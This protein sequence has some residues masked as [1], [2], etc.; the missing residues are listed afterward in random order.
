MRSSSPLLPKSRSLGAKDSG[1]PRMPNRAC[2]AAWSQGRSWSCWR[3]PERPP[4]RRSRAWEGLGPLGPFGFRAWAAKMRWSARHD[5]YFLS[6]C[7]R[8]GGFRGFDDSGFGIQL[9]GFRVPLG[10]S[11][12]SPEVAPEAKLFL[13][14][15][16]CKDGTQGFL[17]LQEP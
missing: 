1:R 12:A 13:R 16:A 11:L 15:A 2:C 5:V 3:A 10:L 9:I 14:G 8:W 4:L 17:C 6:S 7:W